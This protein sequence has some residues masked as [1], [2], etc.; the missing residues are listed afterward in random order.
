MDFE[1]ENT[2]RMKVFSFPLMWMV[3]DQMKSDLCQSKQWIVANDYG[4]V[5]TTPQ[6]FLL[7]LCT[8]LFPYQR[9][10]ERDVHYSRNALPLD[11]IWHYENWAAEWQN[12]KIPA[13]TQIS[14]GIDQVW[15]E[16]SLSAWRMAPYLPIKRTTEPLIRLCGC[17]FARR[18]GH[19]VGFALCG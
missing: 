16:S 6:H 11:K 2:K 15:S 8:W 5:V 18:T 1:A 4:L 10:I 19:F 17:A 3:W 13:K 7:R 12:D 9:V 14:L